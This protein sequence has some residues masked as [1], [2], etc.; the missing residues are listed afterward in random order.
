MNFVQD[1]C[2]DLYE[3]FK[4]NVQ[5]GRGSGLYICFSTLTMYCFVYLVILGFEFGTLHLPGRRYHLD[6]TLSP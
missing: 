3:L 6:H 2:E 4:V 5:F 1:L